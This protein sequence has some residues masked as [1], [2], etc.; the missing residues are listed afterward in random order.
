[1]MSKIRPVRYNP[2]G[3]KILTAA[4]FVG[5]TRLDAQ[6]AEDS[7]TLQ[8]PSIASSPVNHAEAAFDWLNQVAL[9]S[10]TEIISDII[11]MYDRN[12]KL[13]RS[14]LMLTL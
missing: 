1:M 10:A 12:L 14:Q 6:A 3:R 13:F 7:H 11:P 2:T 4:L 5:L 8:S 9:R